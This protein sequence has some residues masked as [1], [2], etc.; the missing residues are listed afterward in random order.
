M[1]VE[2]LLS[3]DLAFFSIYLYL[4]KKILKRFAHLKKFFTCANDLL[5]SFFLNYSFIK[6]MRCSR[7]E[8]N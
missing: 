3:K 8:N 2:F 7:N 1:E 6:E 4:G 5:I